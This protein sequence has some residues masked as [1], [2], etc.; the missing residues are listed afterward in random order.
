MAE[1]R[2]YLWGIETLFL[3]KFFFSGI[4]RCEPTYEEL[5][6]GL[7]ASTIIWAIWLLRAYL[8]GIETHLK[9]KENSIWNWVASLPMRNWNLALLFPYR[10]YV[11]VA[12]LPMRNWNIY[13]ISLS[14]HSIMNVASLPMRNWNNI[15]EKIQTTIRKLLRAYLWGIETISKIKHL[16][17]STLLRVYLWGIETPA[18]Q[19]HSCL[20]PYVASLPMRNWNSF[21]SR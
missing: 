11:A 8:W 9:L 7:H 20:H 5:K 12:S 6:L 10:C 16:L 18:M 3:K 21:S 2:A 17:K 19:K 14:W 15:S 1:L 13:G 4:P